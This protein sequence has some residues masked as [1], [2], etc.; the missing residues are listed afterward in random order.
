[1]L[2]GYKTYLFALFVTVAGALET[3]DPQIIRN[4]IPD[5]FEGVALAAIGLMIAILRT[6]TTTPPMKSDKDV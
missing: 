4:L 6:V 5:N 1:M 2:K 3:I